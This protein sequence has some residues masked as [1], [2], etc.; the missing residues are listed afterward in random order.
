MDIQKQNERFVKETL[1]EN[2][3]Y[4]SELS[5]GQSPEYFVL[6][7]C[8]SRVSPSV[9]SQ[10][11]L[12]TMFVHRNIANQVNKDDESFS[13]SLYYALY[14]L[15]VKK[16]IIEGHTNCGGVAAACNNNQEP[17]LQ[18]WI[19]SIK[20]NLP[21]EDRSDSLSLDDMS[22]VNVIKQIEKLKSHPVYKKYGEG[23]QI[24]GFL[25]HL[26]SGRLEQLEN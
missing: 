2:K 25:F 18:Y 13:A 5:K 15:K 14:H 17:E 22:R 3:L 9:I 7:C 26:D 4:F 11:P 23:I 24:L 12:G 8:D 20:E 6:S 1:S 16:I 21:L 10:M 19:N